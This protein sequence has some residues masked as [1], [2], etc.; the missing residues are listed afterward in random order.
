MRL[1]SERMEGMKTNLLDYVAALLGAAWLLAGA[2]TT[3]AARHVNLNIQTDGKAEHCSDLR[4]KSG[5]EIAQSQ[6][7]ITLQKSEAPVLEIS[8]S[9]R[10]SIRVV[11]WDRPEYSVETC[12]F[13]AAED[14]AGAEQILRGI[15]VTRSAGR[16]SAGGP[17]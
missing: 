2:Q 6:E 16:L 17:P 7:A 10:A 13:A 4:A 12:K 11:A 15:S 5:G 14:R 1:P 3:H 8:G 9:D